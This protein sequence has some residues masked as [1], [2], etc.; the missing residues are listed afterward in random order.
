MVSLPPETVALVPTVSVSVLVSVD[1]AESDSLVVKVEVAVRLEYAYDF[2]LLVL[3]LS[4]DSL[5]VSTYGPH[6]WRLD[7]SVSVEFPCAVVVTFPRV[8]VTVFVSS[9]CMEW[10]SRSP[11][12]RV[13]TPLDTVLARRSR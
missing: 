2:A 7:E 6:C 9:A 3:S 5:E 4:L 8:E 1:V 10:F 11:P 13:A 12:P